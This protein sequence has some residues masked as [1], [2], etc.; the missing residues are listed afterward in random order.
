MTANV[1]EIS[2]KGIELTIN[3]T[4]VVTRNFTW[5]TTLNISHNKNNVESLSNDTYSVNYK[6]YGNRIWEVMPPLTCNA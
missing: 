1:G 6:D 5:S 3:A 2:N 4:P